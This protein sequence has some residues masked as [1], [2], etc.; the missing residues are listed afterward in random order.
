MA[1]IENLPL[2]QKTQT[3]SIDNDNDDNESDAGEIAESVE[4]QQDYFDTLLDLKEY[5]IET[6]YTFDFMRYSSITDI[7]NKVY[8]ILNTKKPPSS[9]PMLQLSQH[10]VELYRLLFDTIIV[11]EDQNKKNILL[12]HII[13]LDRYFN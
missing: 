13:D 11:E 1:S 5:L 3:K 6:S 4:D 8:E 9:A 2:F 7:I 10:D 12:E